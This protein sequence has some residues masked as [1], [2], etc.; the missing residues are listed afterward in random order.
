M[1]PPMQKPVI[2]ISLGAV[3]PELGDDVADVAERV[4]DT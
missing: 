3:G 1:C 4:L 2:P